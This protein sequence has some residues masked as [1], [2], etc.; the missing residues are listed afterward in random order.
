MDLSKGNEVK[1]MQGK[2]DLALDEFIE[3]DNDKIR[4]QA[5]WKMLVSFVVLAIV[6]TW[7]PFVLEIWHVKN[8]WA[9][10]FLVI[11]LLIVLAVL[12]LYFCRTTKV[13]QKRL[14]F[15]KA[16]KIWSGILI[17]FMLPY[18]IFLVMQLVDTV[19]QPINK[20]FAA[21][22]MAIMAA[23]VEELLFRGLLFNSMLSFF[24]R[25][26]YILLIASIISSSLF[27]LIHLINASHQHLKSTIGQILVTFTM[28]LLFIYLRLLSN[29][30]IWCI[31]FHFVIDFKPAILSSNTGTHGAPLL[32][33]FLVLLPII[34]V[35]LICIWLFNRQYLKMNE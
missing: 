21:F 16:Q 1:M 26:R 29:G 19:R 23:V 35:G 18:L 25:Q 31:I 4:R 32:Q 27:G 24:Y 30:I 17:V 15:N 6:Y 11:I 22:M 7:R 28:G 14:H 5:S 8:A 12:L 33:V 10:N 13:L 2:N 34:I 9:K 3:F 20:I